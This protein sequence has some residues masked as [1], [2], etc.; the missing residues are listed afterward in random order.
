MMWRNLK[1]QSPS[2]HEKKRYHKERY[3]PTRS[4]AGNTSRISAQ[5]LD[6][7]SR[8]GSKDKNHQNAEIKKDK[9]I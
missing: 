3:T 4:D 5:S 2:Q 7:S 9:T 6:K 1:I 8:D